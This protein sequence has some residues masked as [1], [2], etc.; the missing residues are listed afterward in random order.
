MVEQKYELEAYF[1]IEDA[2][3]E[4]TKEN[5]DEIMETVIRPVLFC[6]DVKELVKQVAQERN[7]DLDDCFIKFSIDTGKG[8]LIGGIS[9]IEYESLVT[10]KGKR[11]RY[12]DGVAPLLRKSASAHRLLVIVMVPSIKESYNNLKLIMD[13]LPGTYYT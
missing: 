4:L 9:I 10:E 6:H 3:F 1:H 2:E 13:N 7:V 5:E 8:K 12:A 11:A